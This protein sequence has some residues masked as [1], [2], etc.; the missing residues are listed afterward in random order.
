MGEPAFSRCLRVRCYHYQSS[1]FDLAMTASFLPRRTGLALGAT[2]AGMLLADAIRR[3]VQS[4][5]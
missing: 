1:R 4:L 3:A 2:A 5:G